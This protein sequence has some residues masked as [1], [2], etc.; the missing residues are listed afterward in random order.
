MS[1]GTVVVRENE[2]S[3]MD[4]ERLDD[5]QPWSWRAWM[6]A[7]NVTLGGRV[8]TVAVSSRC[9]TEAQDRTEAI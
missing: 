5:Q 3:K 2:K 9:Q 6:G 4:G 1:D 7:W 8:R